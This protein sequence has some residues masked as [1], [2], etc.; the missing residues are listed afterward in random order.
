MLRKRL[1]MSTR[2]RTQR[3]W[4]LPDASAHVGKHV[5][6]ARKGT[7]GIR[8]KAHLLEEKRCALYCT[9]AA[10]DAFILILATDSSV[11]NN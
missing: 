2:T 1:A 9:R 11:G 6:A 5:C 7:D 4:C 10:K 8:S 3:A